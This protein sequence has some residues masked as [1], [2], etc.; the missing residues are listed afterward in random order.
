MNIIKTPKGKGKILMGTPLGPWMRTF[1]Y[2]RIHYPD[3]TM[4]KPI[5]FNG[6]MILGSGQPNDERILELYPEFGPKTDPVF[7]FLCG[8]MTTAVGLATVSAAR[9]FLG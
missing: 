3:G 1:G 7:V 2:Y 8:S 4:S 5:R 9:F 6:T